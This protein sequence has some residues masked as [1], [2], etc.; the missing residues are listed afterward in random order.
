MSHTKYINPVSAI[1]KTVFIT[2]CFKTPHIIFLK[3]I[4]KTTTVRFKLR[5]MN[6]INACIIAQENK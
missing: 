4:L 6:V 3:N 1:W 5:H 2:V